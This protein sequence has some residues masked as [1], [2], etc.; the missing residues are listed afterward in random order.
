AGGA[1]VVH[2]IEEAI[3]KAKENSSMEKMKNV[4]DQTFVIGG[5]ALYMAVLPLAQRFYLTR[6]HAAV[7]GDT[8]LVEFN[9][10]EWEEKSRQRYFRDSENPYDFSICLLERKT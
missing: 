5:G 7:P 9:E 3:C 4:V 8:Y 1:S 6:V 2:S 10:S